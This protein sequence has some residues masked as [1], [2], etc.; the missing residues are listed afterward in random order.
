M[1]CAGIGVG[2]EGRE[3][4]IPFF[5]YE[6][7]IGGGGRTNKIPDIR[8]LQY[9]VLPDM[10]GLLCSLLGNR[11]PPRWRWSM[12][13]MQAPLTSL[14]VGRSC[15]LT[16]ADHGFYMGPQDFSLS[17]SYGPSPLCPQYRVSVSRVCHLTGRR[18]FSPAPYRFCS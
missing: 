1:H 7:G 13:S 10:P 9:K 6:G 4:I 18:R 15:T 16:T 12:R 8:Y 14:A 2:G 5:W 11:P 3:C 17:T